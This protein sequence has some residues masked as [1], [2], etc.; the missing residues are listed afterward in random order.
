MR[1]TSPGP[2]HQWRTRAETGAT[3]ASDRRPCGG[4]TTTLGSSERRSIMS[5]TAC[6]VRPFKNKLRTATATLALVSSICAA[7][8]ASAGAA[9]QECGDACISVFSSELGTYAQPNFVEAVLDGG[10]ARIGQPV[11]LKPASRFDATEDIM[12][13]GGLVSDFYAQGIVSAA[14]NSH[15]GSRM[16]VQQEYAPFKNQTGLCVGLASVHQ[17]VGLTLQPCSDATTV[18]IIDAV[19]RTAE[20]YFPIINAATTDYS[21]PFAMHLPR[22]EVVSGRPLQ[23]QARRL[24]FH[25]HGKMLPASQLWGAVSGVLA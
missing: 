7:W 10:T 3:G 19:E 4:P 2:Q 18:W 21:R 24:Q 14:A 5:T 12:P 16:A 1:R 25:G 22:N 15:Y 20:G 23:M 11:G 6:E 8:T 13:I 17:N 9:T